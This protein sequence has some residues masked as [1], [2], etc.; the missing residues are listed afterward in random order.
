MCSDE[1]KKSKSCVGGVARIKAKC[2]GNHE[3]DDGPEA[4]ALFLEAMEKA[5]VTVVSTNTD[6]SKEPALRNISLPKSVTIKVNGVSVGIVGAV[7]PETRFLSNTGKVEFED[8]IASIKREV[9]KLE[10]D[11]IK[12]FVAITHSGYPRDIE[13]VEQVKQ[14][15]LLVG[16]HTNT[17][18]YHGEGFPK[19][20]VPEGDY[21]TIVNRSDG[22]RGLVVQD[23]WFG[24]FLGFLQVYF[25]NEGQIVNWTGNPILLN[26]SVEEGAQRGE[27]GCSAKQ[28]RSGP[29]LP[30]TVPGSRCTFWRSQAVGQQLHVRRTRKRCS[31]FFFFHAFIFIALLR[32]PFPFKSK[33]EVLTL[34]NLPGSLSQESDCVFSLKLFS[35]TSAL[36]R[37][38]PTFIGCRAVHISMI[39]KY[40]MSS[41]IYAAAFSV[42][43]D[44]GMLDLIECYK[45]NVT[46]AISEV[47]GRSKVE[48]EQADSICRLRECNLGNLKA[49]GLFTYYAD[50]ESSEPDFWSDVNGAILNG[51]AVRTPIPQ[52]GEH[53]ALT[54]KKNTQKMVIIIIDADLRASAL[55]PQKAWRESV[56]RGPWREQ[57]ARFGGRPKTASSLGVWPIGAIADRANT[58]HLKQ[59]CRPLGGYLAPLFRWALVQEGWR[60][61]TGALERSGERPQGYP[62]S[63]GRDPVTAAGYLSPARWSDP[64]VQPCCPTQP[65][66]PAVQ[67]GC[68]TQPTVPAVLHC[69]PTPLAGIGS[70][71]CRTRRHTLPTRNCIT[72][73]HILATMPFGMSVVI[74]TLNGSE[75]RSMFEYSVS[76]YSYKEKQGRFLQVSGIR[77]A[78]N[79]GYPRNCRVVSLQVLCRMCTVPRY[80]EVRDTGVY[81]IVTTDYITRGGDGY[82][83]ATN[84][85]S[86]GPADYSVLV[87]HVRKMT[88]VKSALEGRITIYNGSERATIPGDSVTNPSIAQE[89]RYTICKAAFTPHKKNKIIFF[90]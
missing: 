51:G 87:N 32:L 23:Y 41:Y 7:L 11:G 83:K 89:E 45:E 66:D 58:P 34:A 43:S 48:L 16:G 50:K 24:K 33:S 14:L 75:L 49:D 85:T 25:D 17:F 38:F 36:R 3:F 63:C 44:R 27:T 80:E 47:I 68:P 6:F 59:H 52:G 54:K 69:C 40:C 15:D 81:R 26:N 1:D 10:E 29:R 86:G 62:A 30:G 4:L 88:P 72:M 9:E 82:N 22:S 64:A 8:E 42:P 19:E 20:N 60:S 70:T 79:V 18:L 35:W 57:C 31:F 55:A 21:P 28:L 46:R 5:N 2:L 73:G 78:Y 61:G 84:A 76:E 90:A 53:M 39:L 67:P 74:M 77:V 12:V 65:T 56:A 71:R 13:I 37:L